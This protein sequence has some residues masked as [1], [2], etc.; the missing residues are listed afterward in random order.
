MRFNLQAGKADAR[1]GLDAKKQCA[2]ATKPPWNPPDGQVCSEPQSDKI[3]A[4]SWRQHSL[5]LTC[6]SCMAGLQRLAFADIRVFLNRARLRR[7]PLVDPPL[8]RK[9]CCSRARCCR[10]RSLS[11]GD[12][13]VTAVGLRFRA[14]ACCLSSVATASASA[15][16]FVEAQL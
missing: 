13:G 16:A 7:G 5:Q 12:H 9:S 3:R 10:L 2:T 11:A 8:H 6:N 14:C 1:E 4:A 15:Q